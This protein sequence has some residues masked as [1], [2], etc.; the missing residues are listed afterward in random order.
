MTHD[1]M[2]FV[3]IKP[4]FYVINWQSCRFSVSHLVSLQKQIA[5]LPVT[6][7]LHYRYGSLIASTH[8]LLNK[9]LQFQ[10]DLATSPLKKRAKIISDYQLI[11]LF[12]LN[13]EKN[14]LCLCLFYR[15]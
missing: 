6:I 12:V 1:L 13:K 4:S 2:P 5:L 11:A 10:W 8:Q 9:Q 14:L 15:Y 3:T 7:S